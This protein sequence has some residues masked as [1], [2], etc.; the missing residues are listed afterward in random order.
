[1]SLGGDKLQQ[2]RQ[3]L[4]HFKGERRASQGSGRDQEEGG[5]AGPSS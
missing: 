2:L 5:G 1:M 4:V 3:R